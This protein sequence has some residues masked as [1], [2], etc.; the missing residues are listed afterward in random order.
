[1]KHRIIGDA[2]QTVAVELGAGETVFGR[3]GTLLFA[4]GGI[5][6]ETN[7]QSA[8]WSAV[9][10]SLVGEGEPP[11]VAYSCAEGGGLAGFRAPSAGRIHVV[12]LDGSFRAVARRNAFLAA[13]VGV[14][15][16]RIHLEGEDRGSVPEKAFVT[17][18]GSGKVFLHGSGNL[19]DFN[20]GA[21]ERMIVDGGMI[22]AL[23]GEIDFSPEPVGMPDD[24]GPLPYIMLMHL[25]GPGR[26]VLQTLPSPG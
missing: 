14:Q 9:T 19:V 3:L 25:T 5:K 12:N 4:R 10:D 21:N 18:G 13:A 6:S 8:Y 22:V 16:D 20:L 24:K 26:A 11:I 15:C 7:P 17:L 2:L 1:M 23:Y